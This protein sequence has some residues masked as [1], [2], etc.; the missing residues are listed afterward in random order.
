MAQRF[1]ADAITPNAAEWDEHHIFRAT[2]C[3]PRPNSASARSMCRRERRDRSR[4]ARSGADHGGDGLWLPLHLRVHLDP[5]HGR[6]DDRPLRLGRREGALSALAGHLRAAGEL[7][8]DRAGFG[9]RRVRAAHQGGAG[10]RRLCRHRLQGVHLGGGEN[11]V[12]VTMVG[13]G[14]RA[15]R[16]FPAW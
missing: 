10:R 5:Q 12:Y 15:P 2:P 1:T 16:A 13:P 6:L 8:P 14:A 3:A 11:E 7:L 9:L 4:A